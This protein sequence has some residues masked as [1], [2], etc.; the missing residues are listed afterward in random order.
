MTERAAGHAADED[1]EFAGEEALAMEDA[2]ANEPVTVLDLAI[3]AGVVSDAAA[4]D[5]AAVDVA[6]DAPAAGAPAAEAAPALAPSAAGALGAAAENEGLPEPSA[7]FA[8]VPA[9][10]FDLAPAP[11]VPAGAA[12]E[13][14][15]ALAAALAAALEQVG[16]QVVPN[17]G[18]SALKVDLAVVDPD[19]PDRYCAGILLD[20]A[21]YRAARTTRDRDVLRDEM[22]EALGWK[23]T[24]VWTLDCYNNFDREVKCVTAFLK[25]ATS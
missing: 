8:P 25:D 20:G 16:W 12:P 15:D 3:A 7:G 4:G 23:L 1:A 5:A 19:D 24:H 10:G 21:S 18:A 22:L 13:H 2:D 14:T 9:S 11:E 17:V 6:G